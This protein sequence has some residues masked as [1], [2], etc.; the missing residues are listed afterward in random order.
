MSLPRQGPDSLEKKKSQHRVGKTILPASL[1]AHLIGK[2]LIVFVSDY[3]LKEVR[4][5]ATLWSRRKD[6]TTLWGKVW[7]SELEDRENSVLFNKG[8]VFLGVKAASLLLISQ[9]KRLRFPKFR[10]S[11]RHCHPLCVQVLPA[12]FASP[13]GNWATK[14]WHRKVLTP[15]LLLLLWLI[16]SFVSDLG[17]SYFSACIH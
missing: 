7:L 3:H 6:C 2:A 13:C 4:D 8:T 11:L 12:L 10:V 9:Y 1:A 5:C 15:K 16:K 17:V 14:N